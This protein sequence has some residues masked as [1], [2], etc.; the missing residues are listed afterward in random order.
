[1]VKKE[2]LE[3]ATEVISLLAMKE[4]M[5]AGSPGGTGADVTFDGTPLDF[6]D[7]FII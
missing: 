6:D 2:Y 1:M 5:Q 3:P 4:T 7:V